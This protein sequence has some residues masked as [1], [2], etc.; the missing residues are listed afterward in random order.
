MLKAWPGPMVLSRETETLAPIVTRQSW[1]GVQNEVELLKRRDGNKVVIEGSPPADD[2]HTA[3]WT[4]SIYLPLQSQLL[5]SQRFGTDQRKSSRS[6]IE[7]KYLSVSV[8]NA[9]G[10]E[11]LLRSRSRPSGRSETYGSSRR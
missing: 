3:R 10:T 6:R 4:S 7:R 2:H 8:G 1:G 11:S 9:S 5:S